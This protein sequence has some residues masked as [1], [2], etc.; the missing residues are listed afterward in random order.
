[1]EQ[2]LDVFVVYRTVFWEEWEMTFFL[3]FFCFNDF[4]QCVCYDYEEKYCFSLMVAV[5]PLI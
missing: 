4:L 5:L 1:M 3:K 2:K